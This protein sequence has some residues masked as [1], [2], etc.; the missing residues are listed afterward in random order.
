MGTGLNLIRRE[1][2]PERLND[3][4]DLRR[5][6]PF[7]WGVQD[8]A[9]FA[10]ACVKAMTDTTLLDNLPAW[11]SHESAKAVLIDEGGLI[12]AVSSRLP[13]LPAPAARRGDVVLVKVDGVEA[14]GVC[15]GHFAAVPGPHG[16]VFPAMADVRAAWRVGD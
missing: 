9:T 12:A 16:L 8:C 7:S 6:T 15:L 11:T 3:V 10:A 2:W 13:M 4:V 1:D 14:L 5:A